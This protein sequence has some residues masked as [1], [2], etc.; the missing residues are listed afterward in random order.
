[1]EKE[2][3]QAAA[4]LDFERAARLRD[5]IFQLESASN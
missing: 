4:R 2:M 1:M 3:R 5:R